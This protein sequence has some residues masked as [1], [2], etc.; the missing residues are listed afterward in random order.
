MKGPRLFALVVLLALA[1]LPKTGWIVRNEVDLLRGRWGDL[2]AS[3]GMGESIGPVPLWPLDGR[4]LENRVAKT[5]AQHYNSRESYEDRLQKEDAA[6]A[7]P[8][9]RPTL[10]GPILRRDFSGAVPAEDGAVTERKRANARRML[11]LALEG[12]RAEPDNAFYPSSAWTLYTILDRPQEARAALERAARCPRYDDAA[13]DEEELIVRGFEGQYGYRGSLTRMV[14]GASV[15]LPNLSAIRNAAVRLNRTSTLTDDRRKALLRLGTTMIRTSPT[16]IGMIVGRSVCLEAIGVPGSE[17]K[18]AEIGRR[19]ALFR[20]ENPDVQANAIDLALRVDRLSDFIE[21]D[22]LPLS[23]PEPIFG[24]AALLGL[25]GSL[26]L[27]LAPKEEIDDR[28]VARLRRAG[29]AW[30]G[31]LPVAFYDGR[32]SAPGLFWI[33]TALGVASAV[34]ARRG[35]GRVAVALGGVAAVASLVGVNYGWIFPPILW[36]GATFL[37]AKTKA[38]IVPLGL[39]G[40][41]AAT[42][43]GSLHGGETYA[44]PGFAIGVAVLRATLPLPK[45]AVWIA[46]AFA[47]L[48]SGTTFAELRGDAQ[49]AE[50]LK[51]VHTEASR[52]RSERGIPSPSLQHEKG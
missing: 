30:I 12:E 43:Y 9:L 46:P 24:A 44:L 39:I 4:N 3:M 35:K 15:L 29:W 17:P 48:Y 13:F 38:A 10:I 6:L 14:A 11:P 8:V 31:F 28:F 50:I 51:G 33:L 21:L 27:S 22:T 34:C 32:D 40:L 47:V 49:T 19:F 25:I 23:R 26:I 45:G 7:D 2:G 36:L 1:L 5:L 18:Q 20:K 37:P 41:S 16:L 42:V 52:F